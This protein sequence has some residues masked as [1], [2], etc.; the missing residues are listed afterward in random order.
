MPR[1]R[2]KP[3]ERGIERL[4]GGFTRSHG[5][6]RCATSVSAKDQRPM[7]GAQCSAYGTRHQ[8]EDAEARPSVD[9]RV[10]SSISSVGAIAGPTP[11]CASRWQTWL[12]GSGSECSRPARV[13]RC[14]AN[15]GSG[16][17]HANAAAVSAGPTSWDWRCASQ[18]D[19][20]PYSE[21]EAVAD[22]RRVLA[23]TG[24][25]HLQTRCACASWLLQARDAGDADRRR[26]PFRGETRALSA[27]CLKVRPGR[28]S[29]APGDQGLHVRC[30]NAT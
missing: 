20:R 22:A 2:S 28:E 17:D 6:A 30:A 5:V 15:S 23:Q 16:Q 4:A 29:G 13:L 10:Q 25:R 24:A 9:P 12:G 21:Q 18:Q 7:I 27:P 26:T 19:R 3:H 14:P 11:S 1:L 8:A